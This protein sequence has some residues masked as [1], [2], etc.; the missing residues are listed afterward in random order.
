MRG[1]LCVE[2]EN[3]SWSFSA[4]SHQP[5]GDGRKNSLERRRFFFY[6]HKAEK[7]FLRNLMGV[8]VGAQTGASFLFSLSWLTGERVEEASNSSPGC[9]P[10]SAQRG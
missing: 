5:G 4:F 7:Y 2:E 10:S 3:P 1:R 9:G 6:C 8:G